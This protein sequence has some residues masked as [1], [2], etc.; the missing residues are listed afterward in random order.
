MQYLIAVPGSAHA[1]TRTLIFTTG[2][3]GYFGK[4]SSSGISCG[5]GAAKG[6][7]IDITRMA[8]N[9]ARSIKGIVFM[10]DWI[11]AQSPG[12]VMPL[13]MRTIVLSCPFHANRAWKCFADQ[14]NRHNRANRSLL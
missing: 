5:P 12:R 9:S 8:P 6:V 4:Q 7:V 3:G 10:A 14:H 11:R 1:G 2:G 13:S